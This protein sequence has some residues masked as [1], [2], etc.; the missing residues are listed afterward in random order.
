MIVYNCHIMGFLG[1]IQKTVQVH[2]QQKH[3]NYAHI[4][5]QKIS[6]FS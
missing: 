2:K 6:S 1:Q 3:Y 5:K 4:V